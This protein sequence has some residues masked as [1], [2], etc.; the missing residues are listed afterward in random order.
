M[1]PFPRF[2]STETG[3]RLLRGT[4]RNYHHRGP[5]SRLRVGR[6]VQTSMGSSDPSELRAHSA[7]LRLVSIAES[8]LD[9]LGAELTLNHVSRID[10]VL[11]L[12]ILE[13]E[14]AATSN[15]ESRRRTFKR[16]HHVDLKRCDEH[17]RVDAAVLVRNAIAHGLGKLTARQLLSPETPKKLSTLNVSVV[18]GFVEITP[19]DV[20]ECADYL[21]K[22]LH[23]VDDLVN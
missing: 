22:F 23:S 4:L 17:S 9:S 8:T 2:V 11:R 7:F 6:I 13:K 19:A 3:V 10:E 18:N 15:W 12:L 14:L 21:Q 20:D 5:L 16:H 1:S